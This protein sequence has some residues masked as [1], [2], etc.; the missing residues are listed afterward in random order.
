M[1]YTLK[2]NQVTFKK[3]K[4]PWSIKDAQREVCT[5]YKYLCEAAAPRGKDAAMSFYVGSMDP[6]RWEILRDIAPNYINYVASA[7]RAYS[8]VGE[9]FMSRPMY[10]MNLFL[11]LSDLVHV[12]DLPKELLAAL[13]A[14]GETEFMF[15]ARES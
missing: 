1:S 12:K 13:S 4:K 8:N 11:T 3:G 15:M 14:S 6:R 2:G 7:S 9:Q 5:I 10:H